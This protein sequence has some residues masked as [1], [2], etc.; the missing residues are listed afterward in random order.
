MDV[1]LDIET[2]GTSPG[3]MV[4]SVGAVTFNLSTGEIGDEF[5]ASLDIRGQDRYGLSIEVDTLHWWMHQ[6]P[7]AQQEAFSGRTPLGEAASQFC[8]WF[9]YVGGINI[10]AQGMDFDMPIWGHAMRQVGYTV[11]WKFYNCRDTS[12]AYDLARYRNNFHYKDVPREGTYHNA[13]DDA[14]HQVKCLHEAW[15]AL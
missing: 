11:P 10:W 6:S 15:N 8:G 3:C 5:Y 7:E 2:L 12:S 1:M 14:K 13:L 4:L 9:K